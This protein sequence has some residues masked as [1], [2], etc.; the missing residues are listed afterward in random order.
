MGIISK[1]VLLSREDHRD[2]VSKCFLRVISN[3]QRS[4]QNET[5]TERMRVSPSPHFICGLT[6][7]LFASSSGICALSFSLSKQASFAINISI[8]YF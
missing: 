7:T 8:Q 4:S 5:N 1:P 6:F 2:D 3:I